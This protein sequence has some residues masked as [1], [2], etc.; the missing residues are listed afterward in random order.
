MKFNDLYL[1]F[2][3]KPEFCQYFH[4]QTDIWEG[5]IDDILMIREFVMVR[6]KYCYKFADDFYK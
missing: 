6:I 5:S 3:G 2:S 1:S 4:V